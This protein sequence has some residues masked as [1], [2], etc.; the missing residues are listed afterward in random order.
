[1]PEILLHYIWQ[2]GLFLGYEQRTSSG[3]LVEVLSRGT[4]NMNA[5]PDFTNVHLRIDGQEWFGEIEI[6]VHSSD[7]YKHKHEKDPAYDRVI[8]HVVKDIDRVVYNTEGQE[9]EQCALQYPGEQDYLTGLLR[10]A[11]LMDSAVSVHEC[12]RKLLQEPGL[13]TEGW[14]KKLIEHRLECKKESIGRLLTI[15]G[16]DWEQAFYISLA[17]YFGFHTNGLPFEQIAIATPLRYL[18]KHR[19]SLFQLTAIL[20]GQAGLIAESGAPDRDAL[21]KEYGFLQKKFGLTPIDSRL[22][23]RGRM[24][25]QN[26]PEVRVRQLA[27]LL[28][29]SEFLF[30]KVADCQEI[31]NAVELFTLHE[32]GEE[33]YRQVCPVQKIGQKSI[34]TLVI[35]TVVPYLYAKGKEREAMR[36]LS[37]M[38]SEDNSIIRQWKLLGQK[39]ETAADSQALIHLYMN[40]CSG[41]KCIN[42]EVAYQIFVQRDGRMM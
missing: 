3:K 33:E 8:L 9:I 32:L 22:W 24:R 7:W 21:A 38:P 4:H 39:V 15:T 5:G 30:A 2:Q 34:E 27:Q 37:E 12:G 26:S 20:M 14:R 23:K 10:D 6:H 16:H 18:Q 29:E 19:N 11:R 31:A 40:Y 25:P 28:Y 35:N 17:H 42:C 13:L 41:S 1:M 36:L